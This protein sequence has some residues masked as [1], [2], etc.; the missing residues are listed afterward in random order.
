MPLFL[1]DHSRY[2]Q[3]DTQ[4]G[5]R[6]R[7]YCVCESQGVR[8]RIGGTSSDQRTSAL[9]A[10]GK[11]A[12]RPVIIEAGRRVDASDAQ[13]PRFPPSNLSEVS[14][15]IRRLLSKQNPQAVVCSPVCGADLLLLQAAGEVHIEQVVLLPSEP[16]AFRKSSVTDRPGNWGEPMTRY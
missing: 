11:S 1:R 9:R 5:P 2:R 14:R 6:I 16:E 8:R 4:E 15:R 10:S 3:Y 13:V 12:G 7:R